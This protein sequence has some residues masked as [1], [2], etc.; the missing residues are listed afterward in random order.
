MKIDSLS[1]KVDVPETRSEPAAETS[2]DQGTHGENEGEEEEKED[3]A[4][5]RRRPR[6]DT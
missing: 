3:I 1:F 2:D 6:R 5:P 4:A